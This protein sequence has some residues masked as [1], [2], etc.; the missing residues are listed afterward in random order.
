MQFRY[1]WLLA[2]SLFLY[3]CGG[4]N[5]KF[6]VIGNVKNI[7][8][9]TV[10]LEEINMD[11][12]VA[13]DSATADES[14]NFELEGT[15]LEPHLYRLNFGEGRFILLSLDKGNVKVTADW[16]TIENYDVSGSASSESL[17]KLLL[18]VREHMRDLSKME[19]VLD[20]LKANNDTLKL[21]SAI[22]SR[23]EMNVSLTR[24]LE[25]YADT[26]QY[27][28]NAIFAAQIVN[29]QAEKEFM[30]S[31]IQ[32]LPTR[33]KDSKLAKEF[34][35]RY[36]ERMTAMNRQQAPPAAAGQAPEISLQTPDGKTVTL[37]SMRGKY[38]LVDFWASWCGPC[39]RENPNVVRAYN[40]FKDKNFTIL[41]VS[42]DEDKD[43]WLEA[44]KKD[45]L[46]WTHVSDLKGWQ[47][48]AA[49]D[50]NVNAIPAN[51]LIDPDG[52]IIASNLR[53]DDL[54]AKLQEVLGN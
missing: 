33:F 14:G 8:S 49:R 22:A 4:G 2:F 1:F 17:K 35:D 12:L 30:E 47:S 52:N 13:I 43:K 19:V 39:R 32:G 48:L 51:F 6:T 54:T 53:A 10:V 16:N 36:N 23:K 31:F 28:P 42:L 21:A 15:A 45:G 27:L 11:A 26:T 29:P 18:V 50:Y 40:A 41:G 44:I 5:N 24:Y 7:P 3:S 38:V 34:T 20:S 9:G 46:T 37:S 25:Q